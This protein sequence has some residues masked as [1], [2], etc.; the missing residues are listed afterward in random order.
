MLG[1][2]RKCTSP[3]LYQQRAPSLVKL[4]EMKS[5]AIT[6]DNANLAQPE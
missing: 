2:L 4:T 6:Q 3:Q 1:V 5:V